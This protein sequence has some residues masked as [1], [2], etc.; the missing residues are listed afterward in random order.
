MI[1]LLPFSD[2]RGFFDRHDRRRL[3]AGRRALVGDPVSPL[4]AV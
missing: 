4:I 3:V 2:L 1:F